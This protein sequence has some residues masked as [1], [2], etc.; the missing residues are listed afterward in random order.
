MTNIETKVK[1]RTTVGLF[2]WV[3]FGIC[4]LSF[5]V[6]IIF[7]IANLIWWEIKGPYR[8]ITDVADLDGDGDLDVVLGQTRWETEDISWAGISLWF[9]QGEGQFTPDDQDLPDGFSAAASDLDRDGDADLLV[10]EWWWVTYMLNQGGA[11]GGQSG[12]FRAKDSHIGLPVGPGHTDMGGSLL[13]GDLNNDGELDS[14]EVGC[15]YLGTQELPN[16]AGLNPSSSSAILINAW[17][18]ELG[19]PEFH[20]LPLVELDGIPVRGAALGD[21]DGDGDLDV[22]TAVGTLKPGGSRG[23]ADMVLLNDGTGNFHDSGQRLGD[24]GSS[25]VALGDLDGDGDLDALVGSFDGSFVW[26]NQGGTQG[27]QAGIFVAAM[28]EMPGKQTRL[29]FLADLDGDGDQDALNGGVKQAIIWWNNG[30]GRFTRSDQ[31]FN[32]TQR[33]SL[34]VADFNSDGLADIFAGAYT[35]DYLVWL[36]QGG[37][38]FRSGNLQ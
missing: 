20:T 25:S 7:L 18:D 35:D 13:M 33:H 9:N 11:Q 12:I 6:F 30:R 24:T 22:Y 34:A 1:P 14:L 21:L 16:W 17:A 31:R 10:L 28:Q 32:Y 23:L 38:T 15:C 4:L 26:M 19:W 29:V 27:G 2:L 36:N 8:G 37:G 5:L 3:V